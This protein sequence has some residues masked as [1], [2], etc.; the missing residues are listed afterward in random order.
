[1]LPARQRNGPVN[2][3]PM[4]NVWSTLSEKRWQSANA[5]KTE[6]GLDE[7]TLMRV[8][9]FLVR[10]D[11]AEIRRTPNLHVKRKPGAYSPIELVNVL[12]AVNEAPVQTTTLKRRFRIAERVACRSCGGKNLRRVGANELECAKCSERQWYTIEAR[13][14]FW[15]VESTASEGPSARKRL[16]VQLGRPQ[17]AFTRNIPEPTKFYWFRCPKCKT[18]SSDYEHGHGRYFTC[19]SCGFRK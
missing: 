8:L 6:S 11:F 13:G 12:R 17:F 2:Q 16:L 19:H 18:I 14:S 7:D 1:M 15:E 5:L 9:N 3:M 4:E 10:W